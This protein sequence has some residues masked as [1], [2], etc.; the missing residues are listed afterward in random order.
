VGLGRIRPSKA[1]RIIFVSFNQLFNH[2]IKEDFRHSKRKMSY[3]SPK[4]SRRNS[5]ALKNVIVRRSSLNTVV[6][7]NALVRVFFLDGS[8]KVLQLFEN[9]T[10]ADVLV[11][12]KFNLDLT[13]ISTHAIFRVFGSSIRRAELNEVVADVL[14]DPTDSGQEVRLL[15]R[16][17]ITYK[18]GSFDSEVFQ[19]GHR[20]KQPNT[21]LWL[22]FMEAS[23]M[24][25]T[26]KFFLTEDES[27]ILGCLKLQV[28][29]IFGRLN[30]SNSLLGRVWRLQSSCSQL[31]SLKESSRCSFS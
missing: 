18:Y 15:F 7:L 2:R 30:A 31:R 21:A 13:D 24:I 6:N 19:Y 3:V 23:F 16:S 17:W 25:N 9:S 1:V 5:A 4:V 12:L 8:S 14:R 20:V 10:I 28:G 26:E 29:G 11:A 27:L 22:T